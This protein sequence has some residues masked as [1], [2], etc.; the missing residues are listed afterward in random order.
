MKIL[1]LISCTVIGALALSACTSVP[2]QEMLEQVAAEADTQV[3]VR[4]LPSASFTPETLYALLIAELAGQRERYDILLS[5]YLHQAEKTR[6]AGL[7]ERATRIATYLKADQAALS[8]ATLWNEVE[9]GSIEA[10]QA[11]AVQLIK[12]GGHD[13][14]MD[15]LEEIFELGGDANFEYLAANTRDLSQSQRNEYISRFDSLLKHHPKNNKLLFA[16]TIMLQISGR[17]QEALATAKDLHK[18]QANTQSLLLKI[19]LHHQLGETDRAMKELNDE[20]EREPTNKQIRLLY[21]QLLIDNKMLE[22]AQQ[23]FEYLVRQSP[24]DGQLRLTLALIAME[25]GLLD[26]AAMHLQVLLRNPLTVSEAHF[27]LAQ[28]AE[29]TMDSEGAITHYR[30]VMSGSKILP[31]Y[32]R[33]GQLLIDGDRLPDLQTWFNAARSSNEK[34]AKSLYL[35]EAD[36]LSKNNYVVAALALLNQALEQYEQDI[37]LLYSRAMA[38]EKANNLEEMERDLRQILGMQPDNAMVLNALGYTLANRTD[39]Y[40]EALELITRA[41]ELKPNDPA[42]TDSLGWA[43][44]RLGDYK[45]AIKLLEKALSD[46]PD[47]EVA[48]HLGEVLWITGEYERAQQVWKDALER[49]PDS[50]IIKNVIER[51]DPEI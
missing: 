2:R 30:E 8:A 50:E 22:E 29:Q 11:L 32:S 42:I 47:H 10:K 7:A 15:V 17:L 40:D 49:Q 38:S 26:E 21:A 4:D 35:L 5:S 14:A 44:F 45:E 41:N 18:I 9:P 16:K 43:L 13:H 28:I 12:T 33:L 31:S 25:N 6:D 48:A 24:R 20:L 27:Y 19:R 23:Q 34:Q 1:R 46:Y 37:N 3:S 39:R 51:L 36:L